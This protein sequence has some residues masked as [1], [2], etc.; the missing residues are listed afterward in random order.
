MASEFRML[1]ILHVS[2]TQLADGSEERQIVDF[3]K[4]EQVDILVHTGDLL[5]RKKRPTSDQAWEIIRNKLAIMTGKNSLPLIIIP[6]NHDPESFRYRSGPEKLQALKQVVGIFREAGGIVPDEQGLRLSEQVSL[7][8]LNRF[9]EEDCFYGISVRD[10][11][12]RPIENQINLGIA[13]GIGYVPYHLI[14]KKILDWSMAVELERRDTYK[15]LREII[16]LGYDIILCGH[17]R[18]SNVPNGLFQHRQKL[19][20]L[21]GQQNSGD[22]E[23]DEIADCGTFIEIKGS[24]I[25]VSTV[26]FTTQEIVWEQS[27]EELE[28]E[29]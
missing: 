25:E 7:T 23:L 24:E 14:F 20:S 22:K 13:H 9:C 5:D 1:R 11:V 16:A 27:Y 6:G 4:A 10:P 8:Y 18:H 19:V 12:T 29:S 15:R 26:R 2:D 17:H 3:A 28:N 21:R